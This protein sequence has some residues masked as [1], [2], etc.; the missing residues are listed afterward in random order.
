MVSRLQVEQINQQVD[1][2]VNLTEKK[3]NSHCDSRTIF[4]N[5]KDRLKTMTCGGIQLLNIQQSITMSGEMQPFS[6]HITPTIASQDTI[7]SQE[8]MI[9]WNTADLEEK[10][11]SDA[12]STSTQKDTTET[13]F[14]DGKK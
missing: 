5:R 13:S 1:H 9:I 3:K 4:N 8:I 10:Y 7:T 6:N 14:F 11:L 12:K 2:L